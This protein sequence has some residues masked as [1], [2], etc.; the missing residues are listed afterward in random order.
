M[1]DQYE[2]KYTIRVPK[3]RNPQ[4]GAVKYQSSGY[5]STPLKIKASS[6]EEAKKL[7]AKHETVTKAKTQASKG[8]DYDMPKP[9]VQM[10][11]TRISG[12]GGGGGGIM[13][14]DGNSSGLKGLPKGM[15]RK[16][17]KGG[18]VKKKK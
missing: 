9:R 1:S 16:F 10:S 6:P 5:A 3:S 18:S 17:N 13:T 11:V 2:V 8:L 7:A 14:P 12:K 4:T 15:T